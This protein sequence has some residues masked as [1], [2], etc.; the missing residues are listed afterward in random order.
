MGSEDIH[1]IYRCCELE[2][3]PV[4]REC[5]PPQFSKLESFHSAY[6]MFQRS[7]FTII[8]DGP[9][10]P[11]MKRIRDYSNFMNIEIDKVNYN[12]NGQSLQRSLECGLT[13]SAKYIYFL[14]DDYMHNFK[15]GHAYKYMLDGLT[16]D[17]GFQKIVSLYSHPDRFTRNDDIDKIDLKLFMGQECYW[18]TAESTTCTWAIESD[19]FKNTVY[20][21]ARAYGL[22]DREMFRALY[23]LPNQVRLITSLPA[24][25]THCHEPFM[26][27]FWKDHE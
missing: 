21:I 12:S 27:P 5:R 7:K 8:H 24:Y 26:S 10:G 6:M 18:R 1:V 22:Q 9:D 3:G 19:L 14:E 17:T 16:L 15:G 13:S 11:L 25:S 2:T 23:R 4:K 20:N